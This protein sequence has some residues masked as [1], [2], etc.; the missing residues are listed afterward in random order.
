MVD[1]QPSVRM[2]TLEMP[3]SYSHCINQQMHLIKYNKIE[4][5]KCID[6]NNMHVRNNI[7][8]VQL[9]FAL[10]LFLVTVLLDFR[11]CSVNLLRRNIEPGN[12]SWQSLQCKPLHGNAAGG[13]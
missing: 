3:S 13:P 4:F 10:T 7:T 9:L 5:I 12:N 8:F 2:L 1:I 11:I 6:Y